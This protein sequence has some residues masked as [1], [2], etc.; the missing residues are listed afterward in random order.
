MIIDDLDVQTFRL[1]TECIKQGF[2]EC[3][4]RKFYNELCAMTSPVR[5]R[6]L[7][8]IYEEEMQDLVN[9]G[10]HTQN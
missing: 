10:W 7:K 3:H 5:S 4:E 1:G 9:D 8:V 2:S 6:R